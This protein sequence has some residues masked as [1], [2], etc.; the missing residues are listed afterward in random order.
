MKQASKNIEEQL[1]CSVAQMVVCWPAVKQARSS[2]LGRA[3]LAVLY[4]GYFF[5]S[6]LNRRESKM[7]IFV[8]DSQ[9]SMNQKFFK[10]LQKV[11]YIAEDRVW[12]PQCKLSLQRRTHKIYVQPQD[13]RHKT[14]TLF[15]L[16]EFKNHRH[17][18]EKAL[19][20]SM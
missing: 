12:S 17:L 2:T 14:F 19:A 4:F 11:G 15:R 3:P 16:N 13:C 5:T 9:G 1:G 18:K 7:T 6:N 10:R 20:A 8:N